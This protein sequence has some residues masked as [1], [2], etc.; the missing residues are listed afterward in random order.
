MPRTASR[1]RRSHSRTRTKTI[2]RYI[3]RRSN[4]D[5]DAS[6]HKHSYCISATNTPIM[7]SL[8]VEQPDSEQTDSLLM[9]QPQRNSF[10]SLPSPTKSQRIRAI[11][12]EVI[13]SLSFL[14]VVLSLYEE[15]E[16]SFLKFIFMLA[17]GLIFCLDVYFTYCQWNLRTTHAIPCFKSQS[18]QALDDLLSDLPQCIWVLLYV[19]NFKFSLISM[20]CGV[21][22]AFSLIEDIAKMEG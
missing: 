10:S 5:L 12:P 8:D 13:N 20:V 16:S 11:R 19:W 3:Q 18:T 14:G 21:H 17:G 22:S 15:G 6:H 7:N 2:L 1:R 9:S 4:P